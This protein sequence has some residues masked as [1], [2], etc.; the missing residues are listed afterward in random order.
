MKARLILFLLA[1]ALPVF[2]QAS[3]S[4]AF[5]GAAA[6]QGAPVSGGAAV[7]SP[8][9]GNTLT[10]E[11]FETA[12][13]GY[14][15]TGW[16][17]ATG[18]PNPYYDTSSLTTSKPNGACNRGFMSALT[19]ATFQFN[20]WDSG[21]DKAATM[22]ARFYLCVTTNLVDTGGANPAAIF[23]V[24][25]SEQVSSGYLVGGVV[26]NNSG[27]QTSIAGTGA[28]DSTAVNLSTNTWYLVELK[29]VPNG[30]SALKVNGG[31]EQTF[32]AAGW[33]SWRRIVV[34]NL[35]S[36]TPAYSYNT[37][38]FDEVAVDTV[39]YIGAAP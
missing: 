12:T 7:C 31:A 33:T 34:G 27:G 37:C 36:S 38:V 29:I 10:N 20:Y 1:L 21:G 15:Q 26:L 9:Q 24:M 39:G 2:G 32:T 23:G 11:G 18:T 19:S 14:Q 16:G 22:Y 3:R 28:T 8:A 13:T 30:T 6:I 17:T 35:N 5:R 4:A 25:N